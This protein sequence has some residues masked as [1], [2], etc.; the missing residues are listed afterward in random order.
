EIA[1]FTNLSRDHLDFHHTMESYFQAK[2]K[3]FEGVNG[4][5]PRVMILNA[6][7]ARYADLRS[8][9]PSR[10]ISYG[11]QVAADIYPV[12]YQFGW[13]ATDATFKTPIGELKV[14]TS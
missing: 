8:I 6:D 2:R 9:D 12:R 5:K 4:V 11:M 3:L 1:V 13:E 7:D 10:V 14:Q